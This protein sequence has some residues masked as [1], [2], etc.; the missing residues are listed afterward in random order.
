MRIYSQWKELFL[1]LIATTFS[2]CL[3]D[4]DFERIFNNGEVE[5]TLL[6]IGNVGGINVKF[7]DSENE[8]F[9]DGDKV[10]VPIKEGINSL[11]AEAY[12]QW[13]KD[14]TPATDSFISP[15][16][17]EAEKIIE[18]ILA[19]NPWAY[20][21]LKKEELMSPG[22]YSSFYVDYLITRHDTTNS[23]IQYVGH[24]K[25]LE[26]ELINQQTLLDYGIPS[27]YLWRIPEEEIN[28][29]LNKFINNNFNEE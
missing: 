13:G 19:E 3:P 24:E 28:L 6:G 25:N 14:L 2:S 22:L 10:L 20:D 29:K 27:L 5:Y 17:Q 4:T 15:T 12:N 16:Q 11:W 9:Y 1:F 26:E 18:G 7:N 21:S 23:V 8:V